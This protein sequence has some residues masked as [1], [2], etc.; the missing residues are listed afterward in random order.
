MQAFSRKVLSCDKKTGASAVLRALRVSVVV[1]LCCTCI[2]PLSAQGGKKINLRHADKLKGSKEAKTQRLIGHVEFEHQGAVMYC[3]SAYLYNETNSLE[4]F[5]HVHIQHGDSLHMY[6]ETLKYDGNERKAELFKN[7]SMSD[8]DMILVTDYLVYDLKNKVA[9]YNTGGTITSK[10]N[11]LKSKLGYYSSESRTLTFRK[12]VELFTPEYTMNCDTLR[13]V[14]GTKIAYFMG[15]TTMWNPDNAMYCEDGY[16]DTNLDRG[17]FSKKAALVSNKRALMGDSLFYDRKTRTGMAKGNVTLLDTAR[18]MII[19][20]DLG[21]HHEKTEHSLVTGRAMYT[22]I[23]D[24]DSLFLHADTLQAFTRYDTVKGSDPEAPR[25]D[26]LRTVYGYRNVK[27]FKSDM[28]GKCDSMI[29]TSSDSTMRL[30][31]KPVLWNEQSQLTAE[32]ISILMTNDEIK[33]MLLE[34]TAFIAS[35]EDSTRY[36]QI[37]GRKMTGYFRKSELYRVDVEGNGQTLYFVKDKNE[38]IGVNKVDCSKLSIFVAEDEIKKITF[39]NKP[40]ATLYPPIDLS[41]REAL[42]KD[43]RWRGKERPAKKADIFVE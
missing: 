42:L 31:G 32:K 14:P 30:F 4:A 3:D 23:Y 22:Q 6:G 25:F 33:Q 38:I 2:T 5:G 11:T 19:T 41:P 17:R 28:Q 15:P 35:Q 7:I 8:G 10:G 34:N 9:S 29:F 12:D 13:Y 43:F 27:F 24:K 20:G 1:F 21:I 37:K 36:N 40:D 16:Y 18:K 39:F 26:T